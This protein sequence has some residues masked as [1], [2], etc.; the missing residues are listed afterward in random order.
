MNRQA[1]G[2]IM[3]TGYITASKFKNACHTDPTCPSHSL[4]MSICHP[5]IP[6]F[7]TSEAT[8][9][10]CHYEK[11]ARDAYCRY[12]SEMHVNAIANAMVLVDV[13]L[14]Y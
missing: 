4:I 3:R 6:R 7:N 11:R 1:P 9:W 8:Q 5:E 14:R 12:Q 13:R 10:G 2:F